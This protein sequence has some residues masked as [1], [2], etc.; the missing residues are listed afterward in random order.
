MGGGLLTFPSGAA[1][2]AQPKSPSFS[3]ARKADTSSAG[4]TMKFFANH[5]EE[6]LVKFFGQLLTLVL[7]TW[8]SSLPKLGMCSIR[9]AV[10]PSSRHGHTKEHHV[11]RFHLSS[12][13]E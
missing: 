2:A 4:G 5:G 6:W 9:S 10:V 13:V 11:L 3:S 8:V 7:S 12:K 1:M